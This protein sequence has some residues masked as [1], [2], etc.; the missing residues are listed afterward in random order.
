MRDLRADV[1]NAVRSR[2]V[3]VIDQLSSEI[4]RQKWRVQ[5]PDDIRDVLSKASWALHHEEAI[6]ELQQMVPDSRA[7]RQAGSY[8]AAKQLLGMW[9][10]IVADFKVQQTQE[11]QDEMIAL[12][13]WVADREALQ[14]LQ[15]S[16]QVACDE[17]RAVLRVNVAEEVLSDRLR[18]VQ[19]IGLPMPA[20]LERDYLSI[21]RKK[22]RTHRVE[23]TGIYVIIALFVLIAIVFV[24]LAIVKSH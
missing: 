15:E 13:K 21:K 9:E 12:K 1:T 10:K 19:E 2:N 16:F 22:D 8:V 24:V 5:I 3:K 7:A 23:Q 17:L 18:A 6:E 14:A 11:L 4:V 20:D